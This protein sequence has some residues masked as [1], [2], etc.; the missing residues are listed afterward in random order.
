MKKFIYFTMLVVVTVYIAMP[1]AWA[2]ESKFSEGDVCRA[3]CR[4]DEGVICLERGPCEPIN[5]FLLEAAKECRD[6]PS[7]RYLPI[8]K[9]LFVDIL[10]LVLR[11]DKEFPQNI[12]SLS[13]DER[14]IL[15]TKLLKDKGIDI[16]I[17]TK[18]MSPLTREELALVLKKVN[19]EKDLGFSTGLPSQMFDLKNE[20]FVIYDVAL[21]VDEGTGFELWERK[22]NFEES[23]PTSKDY[24]A[25]LDSCDDARVVFGDNEK[26]KIPLAGSRL[27]ASYKYYGREDEMVTECE[28]AMLLSNPDVAKSLK[29]TYN[30]SRALTKENFVDLLI[31][32]MH[33]ERGLPRDYY[34]ISEQE[35]YRLQT[36]ILAK[37]GIG[38]FV[39]T[40]PSELLT[41]EEL[42]RVLYD[43]PVEEAVGF[44]NGE[45]NQEFGLNNAGFVIYDLHTYVKEGADYEEW[46]KRDGFIESSSISKDYL[47]K[48]D[49]GNYATIYFGD[50]RKGKIPVENSPIKVR[51]RLYAPVSMFTEDDI[52]CVLGKRV[53]VVEAYEPPP[54]PPDFPPPADGFDDPASHI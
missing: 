30:P 15:E 28:I 48:L 24:V 36:Q 52:I 53:P 21:Y 3:N 38:I 37:N 2:V 4:I 23:L 29:N 27:K 39:G 47:V 31:K 41:R 5:K 49:L 33:L 12:D 50:N 25:K 19:V 34:A 8:T 10:S 54:S 17:D 9:L 26:G 35:L 43:S 13:D 42:A 44:S 45:P 7:A 32:A 6:N 51:Y 40:D 14:Y 11:L 20:K 46:N 16:F 1:L 22:K 18:P